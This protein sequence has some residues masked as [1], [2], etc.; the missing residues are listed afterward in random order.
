MMGRDTWRKKKKRKK[1]R[2]PMK[3]KEWSICERKTKWQQGNWM[4]DISRSMREW[5][6]DIQS[7][8]SPGFGP[9]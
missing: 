6:P 7:V 1:E 9:F 5:R 4:R 3:K 2:L 8:S